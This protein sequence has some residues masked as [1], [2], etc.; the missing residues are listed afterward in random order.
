MV[1][2]GIDFALKDDNIKS[3]MT[4]VDMTGSAPADDY[5]MH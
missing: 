1:D 4:Y 5:T 2:G 3:D